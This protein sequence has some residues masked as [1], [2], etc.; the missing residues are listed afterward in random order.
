MEVEVLVRRV[1][2]ESRYD[3]EVR[4]VHLQYEAMQQLSRKTGQSGFAFECC[5]L[6]EK[7]ADRCFSFLNCFAVMHSY[8]F[9]LLYDLRVPQNILSL[10]D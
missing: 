8:G 4:G 7:I 6:Q 5:V 10:H 1:R 9:Q 3:G 2:L